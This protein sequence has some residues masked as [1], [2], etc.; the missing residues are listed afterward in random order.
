MRSEQISSSDIQHGRVNDVGLL[1]IATGMWGVGV[2]DLY[3]AWCENRQESCSDA[4]V[5]VFVKLLI[6]RDCV[7]P[8]MRKWLCACILGETPFVYGELCVL[9]A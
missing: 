1:Y 8:Y 6:E 3:R 7:H 9:T 2:S 4:D 5:E